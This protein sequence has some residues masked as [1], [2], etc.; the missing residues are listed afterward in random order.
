MLATFIISFREF[1]E[2]FLIIGVFFGLEKKLKLRRKK[3]ILA[4]AALGIGISYLLP[5]LTFLIGDRARYVI[6]EK[7]ADILEG[8]LM[9]FSGFFLAYIIFTLHRLFVLKR[10][11]AIIKAHQKL[12]QNIFDL[13][14]FATIVFFIAREGFEIALFTATTVLF[15]QFAEN[16]MGL[17]LGFL[18]SCIVGV[19]TYAAYIRFPIGK[20]YKFTEY[21]IVLLGAA[22]IKNGVSILA[23]AY[24]HIHLSDIMPMRL[25]FLPH[26]ETVV[27]HF[28][29]NFIGLE[30]NF[31][32]ATLLVMVTYIVFVYFLLVKKTPPAARH[33]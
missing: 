16:L 1:L 32:G 6:N 27:G 14:L 9:I 29:K 24:L 26:S 25:S 23:E 15:S 33:N 4:A 10:S 31:S 30:Q 2:V 20:I 7:N 11:G 12:E 3:E 8:Y 28:L 22:F 13:S 19:L 18:G 5:M 21:A 17:T